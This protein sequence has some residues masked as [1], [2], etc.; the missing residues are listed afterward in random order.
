MTTTLQTATAV[1]CANIAFIK[2]WGQRDSALTLPT[3]GSIS[4]NLDGCLTETKVRCD[5][6]GGLNILRCV[7]GSLAVIFECEAPTSCG[8]NDAG[9][10]CIQ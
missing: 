1:A 6:D 7:E 10:T 9:L 2:Y 4:M 3:N 8:I 5:P